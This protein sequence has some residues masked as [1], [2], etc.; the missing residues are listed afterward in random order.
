[1]LFEWFQATQATYQFIAQ[2]LMSISFFFNP[3]N[4]MGR[5]MWDEAAQISMNELRITCTDRTETEIQIE[6]VLSNST[7]QPYRTA[8]RERT[9]QII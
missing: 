2:T 5:E 6:V 7:T 3:W 4:V 9:L 8:T 1:M